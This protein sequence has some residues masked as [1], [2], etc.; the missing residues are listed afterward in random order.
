MK[1]DIKKKATI[2]SIQQSTGTRGV[3]KKK[4]D[5]ELVNG[6]LINYS[7]SYHCEEFSFSHNIVLEERPITP[8]L[9]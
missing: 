7:L 4:R 2:L 6:N 1:H 5:N 3:A 8:I 9:N